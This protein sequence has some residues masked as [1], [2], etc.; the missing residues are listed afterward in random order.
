MLYAVTSVSVATF[1]ATNN[2]FVLLDRLDDQG[3][4]KGCSAV[5]SGNEL[6]IGREEVRFVSVHA[7]NLP[8]SP[9]LFSFSRHRFTHSRRRS[10]KTSPTYSHTHALRHTFSLHHHYTSFSS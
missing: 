1:A 5:T 7:L 8:P 4:D 3:C 10:F 6:V 9:P 2:S